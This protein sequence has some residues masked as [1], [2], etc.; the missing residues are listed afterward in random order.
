MQQT[1]GYL[2]TFSGLT[3]IFGIFMIVLGAHNASAAGWSGTTLGLILAGVAIIG[4][5]VVGCW[6]ATA[7]PGSLPALYVFLVTTAIL[8]VGEV[9]VVAIIAIRGFSWLSRRLEDISDDE[10]NAR[11]LRDFWKTYSLVALILAVINIVIQLVALVLAYLRLMLRLEHG[12]AF[13]CLQEIK[14]DGR[15]SG[16]PI[17]PSYPIRASQLQIKPLGS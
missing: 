16:S 3:S 4:V 5:A 1:S 2:F 15:M 13:D 12:N 11:E 6:S 8:V 14:C 17:R 9:V 10:K 7:K